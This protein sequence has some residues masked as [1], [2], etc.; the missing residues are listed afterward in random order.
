KDGRVW[1]LIRDRCGRLYESYSR[2]GVAWSE[3]RQSRFV[4]SDS[5][6]STLR[7]TDGRI[8]LFWCCNQR[9]DNPRSYAMRGREVLHAAISTDEGKTWQGFR[10]VLVEPVP[11][12]TRGDRG[13]AYPS[14]AQ[15]KESKVVLASG[16]GEG[17]KA[18]VLFDPDWL[19]QTSAADDFSRG[20]EQW[21]LY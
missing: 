8:L 12:A 2:D 21:T 6:A 1:M 16:Q 14:A 4:S 7:L 17:R 9:W 11:P 18:V 3:P 13:C 10:E 15:N 19:M 5:P 20:L